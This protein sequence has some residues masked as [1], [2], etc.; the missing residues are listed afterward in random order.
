MLNIGNPYREAGDGEGGEMNKRSI[1][2]RIVE[3]ALDLFQQEGYH[4]VSVEQIVAAAE[5]SKGGFY[6]HFKSKGD[7][8]Y[9]IHD[10][11]ISYV[12]TE[13]TREIAKYDSSLD[14]MNAM[15]S[16]CLHAFSIYQRH[17][18]VF[19]E[20]SVYLSPEHEA[21]IESKRNMY[22]QNLENILKSGQAQGVFRQELSVK[23]TALLIS[24][25]INW[26][27]RWFKVDG[28]LTMKENTKYFNDVLLRGVMT[29]F[30]YQEAIQKQYL[31]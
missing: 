20:E 29:E 1:K 19:Y 11:F 18:T 8:L 24:G 2:E 31:L 4:G 12:L 15:L 21:V 22:Q 27:Y 5:T 25:T 7:L 30:G 6:H 3:A 10:V 13:T 14:Q 16:T 23:M 28:K 26:T 17:I 9:E